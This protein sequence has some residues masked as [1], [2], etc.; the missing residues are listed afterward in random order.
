[1]I[2][3]C[4]P[5]HIGFKKKIDTKDVSIEFLKSNADGLLLVSYF[6]QKPTL[7]FSDTLVSDFYQ[8]PILKM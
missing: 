4:R 5:F 3:Q 8:K 7:N 1:M 6:Y 2:N